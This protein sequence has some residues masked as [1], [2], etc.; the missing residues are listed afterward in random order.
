MHAVCSALPCHAL[1]PGSP[2]PSVS[3][4]SPPSS[5]CLWHP[6]LFNPTLVSF[7]SLQRTA[8][9]S[10]F[11]D[12]SEVKQKW[13]N[14][15]KKLQ[16]KCVAVSCL[17][18][19][20]SPSAPACDWGSPA[21]PKCLQPSRTLQSH[22]SGVETHN[23]HIYEDWSKKLSGQKISGGSLEKNSWVSHDTCWFLV[24]E[25]LFNHLSK[26]DKTTYKMKGKKIW[27]DILPPLLFWLGFTTPL[28]TNYR[29][30][31]QYRL[32]DLENA[33]P[34]NSCMLKKRH[35]TAMGSLA[36]LL[37][38]AEAGGERSFFKMMISSYKQR[39]QQRYSKA[40]NLWSPFKVWPHFQPV[41]TSTL[42]QT[43]PT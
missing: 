41:F 30:E 36:A 23:V 15:L 24:S 13:H 38:T 43:L 42:R 20:A 9:V 18:A 4:P 34:I 39:P 6:M 17:P 27:T 2:L 33:N 25:W 40:L 37:R 11:S 16:A 5:C 19:A 32:E 22:W 35:E 7:L 26:A 12:S 3:Q 28:Q 14:Q 31:R 8:H 10:V 29:P 21:W 1:S